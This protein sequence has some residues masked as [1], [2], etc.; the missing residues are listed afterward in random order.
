MKNKYFTVFQLSPNSILLALTHL[1]RKYNDP[2]F[3]ITEN[4]W[5]IS[6]DRDLNDDDRV[7]YY[8][9]A[10]ESVLDTLDAGVK[11][12]GYMAWSLMDNFEWMEGYT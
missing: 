3:Y 6:P 2:I 4:G 10:L 11:L 1:Q 9:A 12:K 5:S 8:R 7:S